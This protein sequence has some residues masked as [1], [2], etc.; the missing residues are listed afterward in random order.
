MDSPFPLMVVPAIL[1]AITLLTTI[2]LLRIRR[3]TP[4]RKSIEAQRL[5]EPEVQ[6]TV[7]VSDGEGHTVR[8]ST[9]PRKPIASPGYAQ[10]SPVRTKEKAEGMPSPVKSAGPATPR[11]TRNAAAAVATP[12]KDEQLPSPKTRSKRTP[13]I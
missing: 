3:K 6:G 12:V 2:L 4:L 5:G 10:S 1:V 9:R 7:Y 11:T 13:R 8:R